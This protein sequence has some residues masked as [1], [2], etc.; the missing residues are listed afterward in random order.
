MEK[1][2]FEVMRFNILVAAFNPATAPRLSDAY[3][4]AWEKRVYPFSSGEDLQHGAFGS[5]FHVDKTMI[6][7]L[8]TFLDE[9]W[10]AKTVPTFYDLESKYRGNGGW[11]RMELVYSCTYMKLAGL[12]DDAF[13]TQLMKNHPAEASGIMRK[14]GREKDL[15][16]N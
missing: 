2:L 12:F 10:N 3:V 16:L 9:M 5:S 7:E 15:Y 4:F 14:Y 6:G 13:W 11:D 8:S 1:Q